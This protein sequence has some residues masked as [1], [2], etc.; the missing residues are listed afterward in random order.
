MKIALAFPGVHRRG[1]VERIA[2][3]CANHLAAKG[4]RVEVF[5]TEWEGTGNRKFG[6]SQ[7][8]HRQ[9]PASR[10]ALF[11][12]GPSFFRR[13]S[14]LVDLDAFNV[15][16]SFGCVC[17]LGGVVWVQ[18]VHRAWLE[19]SRLF[20]R[21]FSKLWWKQRLNPAH[22]IIL[23]L[24]AKQFRRG[25][26][27]KL[28]AL[29]P[30][31]KHDLM[32]LYNVPPE[33]IELLP[34]G[35]SPEEFS[36][37]RR[38]QLRD[39]V[40][41]ELGYFPKDKVILFVAN[42]LERKGF[43]ALLRA[44]ESM[45]DSRVHLLAVGRFSPNAYFAE[46]ARRGMSQRVKFPGATSDVARYYAA[47]DAFALPTQ[48]EAWGLVIVEAL[49]CGLPVL[50][51]RIAGAAVAVHE[52]ESGELLDDPADVTE[53]AKKLRMIVQDDYVAED[54]GAQRLAD[55]VSEYAWSQVLTRYERFLQ[56][57][58]RPLTFA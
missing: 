7:I 16:G 31:V 49:A 14:R 18:S 40:R 17:P 3:E 9:V 15:L 50:T 12:A 56:E 47:A 8:V 43:A 10:A 25:N 1:G 33:D 44:I 52:G 39:Q 35:Y 2:Y 53:I 46:I 42:E 30:Q 27:R 5:A 19:R 11:L 55:S 20:R 58:A 34:N 38:M 37:E 36:P 22:P 41:N 29:T 45:G 13:S 4:H 6:G 48:Y 54:G 24:E 32:R 26:Y 57:C 21:T 51:S 23:R 28:L